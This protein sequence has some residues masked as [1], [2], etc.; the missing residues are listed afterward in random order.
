[1]KNIKAIVVD[2][3]KTLL[4]T[5][6]T[7]SLYTAKVLER[8][9]NNAIKIMIATARPLRDTI[10]Y[11]EELSF[12]AMVVSNGARIIC[13]N[14]Q[15]EYGISQ[16]SANRLLAILEHH[17]DLRITLETG[18][19]AYSNKPIEDYETVLT[20]DFKGIVAKEGVLKILVHLDNDK[21]LE[22]VKEALSEDMYYTIA[23]GYLIQIMDKTATKWN[24]VKAMLDVTNCLPEETVYFGDDEDDLEPIKK[25]GVGVAVKNGID[26]VKSAADYITESNDEDGVAKFIEKILSGEFS[27]I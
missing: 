27:V 19:C 12:D 15:M 2:L 23:H 9:K 1:M 18:N 7:I 26:E 11:Y 14:E 5:D 22:I 21:A 20:D 8:C 6:K 10:K 13:E 16:K 17:D 25:C 4:R 3:D 24:G